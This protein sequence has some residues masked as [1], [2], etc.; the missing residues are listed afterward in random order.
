MWNISTYYLYMKKELVHDI[1]E[2]G[3][4]G[5]WTEFPLIDY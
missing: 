5:H 4:E 1:D 2:K 3:N